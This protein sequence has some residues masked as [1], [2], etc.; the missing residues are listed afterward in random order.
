MLKNRITV[1][2]FCFMMSVAVAVNAAEPK[3]VAEGLDNPTG[4]AVQPGTGHVFIASH[5][6][7]HRLDPKSGKVTAEITGYPTPTDIYGKGPKYPIGPLG[8]AFIDESTLI[9]G[10]GSRKDGAELVRIFK[11][12]KTAPEKP[13]SED[14]AAHTLGP[15]TASDK[16]AKGEGNFYGVATNGQ[17]IFITCNGDDTKGWVAKARIKDGKPGKLQLAI[18]TKEATEVDAPGP[19]IFTK[20]KKAIIV[21][22]IGEVTVAG[23]SLITFYS[24]NGKMIRNLTTGLNDLAGLAYSPSGKL[25]GTDF[26]WV[27]AKQGGLFQ[28]ILKKDAKEAKTK[29]I[30]SL[31]KPTGLAFDDAGNC[32]IAVFGSMEGDKPTGK[33]ICISGL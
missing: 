33:I 30:L 13:Q 9:V 19:V 2:A 24:P 26:S 25:Y 1:L 6:G 14:K 23:D 31:D 10:G 32:Y 5:A 22:Q 12:G 7:V 20:S 15:I 28:L 16:T 27:D 29:K 18:A 3:T 4:L 21:G 11:V 17:W 8:L